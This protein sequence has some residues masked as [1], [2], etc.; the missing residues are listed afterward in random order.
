MEEAEVVGSCM[1]LKVKAR[2]QWTA[3]LS[4]TRQ[5]CLPLQWWS[6]GQSVST[7]CSPAFGCPSLTSSTS[8]SAVE[9]WGPFFA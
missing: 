2:Q 1:F 7:P 8:E 3:Q 9:F 6:I 4:Q 5:L